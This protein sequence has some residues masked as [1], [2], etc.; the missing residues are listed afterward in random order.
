MGPE[1]RPNQH[2]HRPEQKQPLPEA[3]QP[4]HPGSDVP[5][6]PDDAFNDAVEEPEEDWMEDLKDPHAWRRFL[7]RRF[8]GNF[9]PRKDDEQTWQQWFEKVRRGKNGKS[10]NEQ[11][12]P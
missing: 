7:E 9:I 11:D 1:Q 6:P 2:Q 12:A 4:S 8:P 10:N 5:P 3:E